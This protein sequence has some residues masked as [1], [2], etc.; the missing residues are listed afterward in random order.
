MIIQEEINGLI[1]SEQR[2]YR[3]YRS[4]K[5]LMNDRP[6]RITSSLESF[7]EIKEEMRKKS[8][9]KK[10]IKNNQKIGIIL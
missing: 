10:K 4:K 8:L 1:F 2:T 3:I 5:D 7:N 6:M 9:K